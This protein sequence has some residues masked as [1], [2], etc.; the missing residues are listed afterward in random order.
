MRLLKNAC[1]GGSLLVLFLLGSCPRQNSGVQTTADKGPR[2]LKLGAVLPFTGAGALIAEYMRYGM[3]LAAEELNAEG[4][5]KIEIL[6]EDS[7]SEPKEGITAFN[8]LIS[9]QDPNAIVIGLSSVASALAPLAEDTNKV[10]MLVC[11]AKPG[12]ADGKL[13][14][15]VYPTAD[16]M[17]GEMAKF[18][19]EQLGIK[20]SAVISLN[21]DF[22][23]ASAAAY[24]QR[25]EE[26]GGKVIYEESYEATQKDFRSTITKL[27]A[28]QP[29]PDAV[30]LCGYGP[31]YG[32]FISQYRQA[33][34]K[35]QL[36]SD[37]STGLPSTLT[38]A[39]QAAEGVYFAEGPIMPEFAAK[40]KKR[41]GKDVFCYSGYGYDAVR[42][43]AKACLEQGTSTQQLSTGLKESKGYIGAMGSVSFDAQGETNLKFA[44]RRVAGGK[45]V[46]A[47]SSPKTGVKSGA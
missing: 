7:Q 37:M 11:V 31:A 13:R 1:L 23:K 25:T 17:A 34:L 3:D 26:S 33:N 2:T 22:G 19:S 21:D 30:F 47:G 41:F 29:Q 32:V 40:F 4:K 14:F 5:V 8:K 39:G 28:L 38:Q 43:L 36:T 46:D 35:P 44:I 9:T 15:R 27:K 12:L 10:Q 20:T 24:R 18:N 45:I 42:L 6:Y 16:G